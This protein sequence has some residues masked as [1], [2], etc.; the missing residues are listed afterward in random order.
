[1]CIIQVFLWF[2]QYFILSALLT[3]RTNAIL[4]DLLPHYRRCEIFF[5]SLNVMY[6][7]IQVYLRWFFV[8]RRV[9]ATYCEWHISFH[10]CSAMGSFMSQK[11]I[12]KPFFTHLVDIRRWYNEGI[13]E[14][15]Q[16]HISVVIV[17]L[18]FIK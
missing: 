2:F 9:L 10:F 17:K 8:S 14:I 7:T 3:Q 1:M 16:I 5:L 12:S 13:G 6:S 11:L 18:P 15:F 4:A